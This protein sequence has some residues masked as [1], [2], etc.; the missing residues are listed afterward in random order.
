MHQAR[1]LDQQR[2]RIHR[3]RDMHVEAR[4]QRMKPVIVTCIRSEG[5]RGAGGR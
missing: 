2:R 3:L 5:D 4:V 1:H